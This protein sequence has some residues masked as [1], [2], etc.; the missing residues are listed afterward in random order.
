M[1]RFEVAGVRFAG[2]LL[3]Y[4]TRT[5][6]QGRGARPPRG[7]PARLHELPHGRAAPRSTVPAAALPAVAAARNP[8]QLVAMREAAAHHVLAVLISEGAITIE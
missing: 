1:L 8:A 5:Q 6:A 7:A 2:G 4:P 3:D